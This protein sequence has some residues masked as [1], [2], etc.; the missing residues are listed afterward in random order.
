[1]ARDDRVDPAQACRRGERLESLA[2]REAVT[3]LMRGGMLQSTKGFRD[4]GALANW[5][6][7]DTPRAFEPYRRR[8]AQ[9]LGL[10]DSFG[11]ACDPLLLEVCLAYAGDDLGNK[12]GGK[13]P[14][15]PYREDEPGQDEFTDGLAEPLPARPLR[16]G[17][18]KSIG[19]GIAS[20]G[21]AMRQAVPAIMSFNAATLLNPFVWIPA[22]IIG[23][24][25]LAFAIYHWWGPISAF[26]ERLWGNI[27]GIFSGVVD[28][29]KTVGLDMMKSLGEGILSGIEYP[30]KAA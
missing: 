11:A 7:E 25:A 2:L 1:V 4:E 12:K 19:S 3:P 20:M 30:F 10:A 5:M 16:L 28:W 24:A 15:D 21:S 14:G 27:R 26:V 9:A 29:L 17:P 13:P 8:A 6:A 23:V 18:A 22:A